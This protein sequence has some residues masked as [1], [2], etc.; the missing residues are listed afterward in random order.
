MI[1]ITKPCPFCGTPA[2]VED[3][4]HELNLIVVFR[5]TLMQSETIR[6]FGVEC[7]MCGARGPASKSEGEAVYEWNNAKW[8]GWSFDETTK[9]IEGDE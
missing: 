4:E 5:D 9:R 6:K 3:G 8:V 7:I 1:E 2:R